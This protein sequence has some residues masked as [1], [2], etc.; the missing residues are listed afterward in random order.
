MTADPAPGFEHRPLREPVRPGER[1]CFGLVDRLVAGLAHGTGPARHG[2]WPP[3]RSGDAASLVH[4]VESSL[5]F[6]RVCIP[7]AR[8]ARRLRTAGTRRSSPLALPVHGTRRSSRLMLRAHS[9]SRCKRKFCD[10]VV[11]EAVKPG[12]VCHADTIS[13]HP[14]QPGGRIP[15]RAGQLRPA[16][17]AFMIGMPHLGITA[18]PNPPRMVLRLDAAAGASASAAR[19]EPGA[20]G[21]RR[22]RHASGSE[23]CCRRA[24][25]TRAW[26]GRGSQHPAGPLPTHAAER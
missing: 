13:G 10:G 15:L 2:L 19:G 24:R 4:R 23:C 8:V 14:P 3:A 22:A 26:S 5:A 21:R 1:D 12:R 18:P 7:D 17:P 20:S 6:G 25:G 11:G 16:E 9:G